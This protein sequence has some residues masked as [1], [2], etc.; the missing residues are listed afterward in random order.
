MTYFEELLFLYFL[1][2]AAFL[3]AVEASY[4]SISR[5]SINRFENSE[6]FFDKKIYFFITH[7]ESFIVSILLLNLINNI[8]SVW[9][10]GRLI[11]K[12]HPSLAHHWLG[13]LLQAGGMTFIL[14]LFCEITP[15]RI[16]IHY[17]K[18]LTYLSVLPL[19]PVYYLFYPVSFVSKSF[20][21]Y[22]IV[23]IKEFIKKESHND[24]DHDE[25]NINKE[26]LMSYIKI[27]SDQGVLEDL[28]SD[29]LQNLTSNKDLPVKSILSPRPT[30]KGFDLSNLPENI[31]LA[32]RRFKY[33]VIP[34][35]DKVK[36]N[37]QGVLFKKKILFQGSIMDINKKN[38]VKHL[39]SPKII[40]ENK[41]II[42]VLEYM[43]RADEEL[44]LVT[45]EYGGIEGFVTYQN[46]VNKLL[47]KPESSEVNQIKKISPR[48]AIV[49]PLMTLSEF[50]HHF[51]T[52]ITCDL[53]ETIGGFLTE[54][55]ND[56]P[57]P[58]DT[59]LT[60]RIKITVKSSNKRLIN[61]LIVEVN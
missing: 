4:L 59:Y 45:D 32:I 18:T 13:P 8:A 42:E 56:I 7:F 50:N 25:S 30:M 55:N 5:V 1:G 10:F 11:E 58:G 31:P 20:S 22:L 16:G 28:E 17:H 27:S 40:P 39:E 23:F 6:R 54:I 21:K 38:L 9:L 53:A 3:S 37:I 48:A 36:D 46:S 49:N 29:M 12:Y 51:K 57:K 35:Y 2:A 60:G 24:G 41:N 14:L 34:V 47:A 52:N 33:N 44:V 15:K 26:E 61:K 19:I 43:R